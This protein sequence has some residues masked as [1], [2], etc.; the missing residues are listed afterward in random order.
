MY[1]KNVSI[2]ACACKSKAAKVQATKVKQ[3]VKT[4]NIATSAPTS[5]VTHRPAKRVIYR[6]SV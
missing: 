5:Q 6:R 4:K 1:D 3:V 2:M